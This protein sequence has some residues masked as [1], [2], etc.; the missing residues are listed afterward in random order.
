MSKKLVV[1]LPTPHE[2]QLRADVS[3]KRR[4]LLNCGRRAGKTTWAARIAVKRAGSGKRVLYIA[5]VVLQTD[6]FW[7]MCCDYLKDAIAI[8][9]V[10]KS[11][12]KRTLTFKDGGRIMAKTGKLPDHLRGGWGDYIILDEYAYQNPIV[13][14][15]VVAPMT[16]DTNAT[17]VFI[18]TPDFRNHF[19]HLYLKALIDD[20]WDVIT[21]SSLENPHLSQEALDDLTKDM[22]DLDYR[23][24]ILA[25]FIPGEGSVF[26]LNKDDFYKG[27]DINTLITLHGHHR[28]VAGIDWGQKND[29]TV[30]SIGCATCQKEIWLE[31][32]NKI[33]YAAQR[34]ILANI[35]DKFEMN[36][37]LLAESNSIGTPNI[38]QLRI[39]GI[40]VNGF[41]MS[42]TSKGSIVQGLRLC[43]SQ[44]SWKWLEN[45]IA[46]NELESYEMKVTPSGNRT[47]NAPY[48]LNDDT[49]I[50]RMLMLHQALTGRF[51]LA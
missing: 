31:R 43:F 1:S 29:F 15:K 45:E 9:Y 12:V 34:D 32:T 42:N 40:P 11:E 17:I 24:E 39:D 20:R 21:F 33:E 49:V 27:L 7:E 48:G 51:T 46:W 14:T 22:T 6:A 2:A 23:Q 3:K 8:G 37:E 44:G 28:L 4:I 38:E 10:K 5:P 26:S 25:E 41:N 19:Y 18:S 16:L 50:A 35:L 13:W 47:Y 30:M 36:V